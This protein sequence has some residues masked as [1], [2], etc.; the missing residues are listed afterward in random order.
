MMSCRQKRD[1]FRL[2]GLGFR[3]CQGSWTLDPGFLILG[4]CTRLRIYEV[5]SCYGFWVSVYRAP[6]ES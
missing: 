1:W 2:S 3:S 5:E 4:S 6:T